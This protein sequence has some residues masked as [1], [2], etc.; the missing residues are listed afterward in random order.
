MRF[1]SSIAAVILLFAEHLFADP[2]S[3]VCA[4][5][6]IA[7]F[8]QCSRTGGSRRTARRSPKPG[9]PSQPAPNT[10]VRLSSRPLMK[11]GQQFVIQSHQMQNCGVQV[12]QMYAVYNC[13]EPETHRSHHTPYR[14]SLRTRQPHG[15]SVWIMVASR[16]ILPFA[17]WHATEFATPDNHVSSS[18]PA[19]PDPPAVLQ[20]AGQLLHHGD[21]DS[22]R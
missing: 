8:R 6:S 14:P 9:R 11:V 13:L 1:S 7:T 21:H 4:S 17:E 22:F 16:C 18:K 19:D 12:V 5:D 15:K 10:S 20:S 3:G 2:D